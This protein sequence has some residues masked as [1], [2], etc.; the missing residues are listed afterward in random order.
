MN[1]VR[2]RCAVLLVMAAA[3]LSS[4][5]ASCAQATDDDTQPPHCTDL[6]GKITLPCP[7]A[8]Q[9]S[10]GIADVDDTAAAPA[11]PVKPQQV[12]KDA[13]AS[14]AGPPGSAPPANTKTASAEG[15]LRPTLASPPAPPTPDPRAAIGLYPKSRPDPDPE[16]PPFVVPSVAS[17]L[18]RSPELSLARNLVQDQKDIW[19]SPMRLR[20]YDVQWLAPLL[21]A[22]TVVT[23]SDTDIQR[24]LPTSPSFQKRSKQFGNYGAA[25][26]AGVTGAAWMWGRVTHNDRLRETGILSGEAALDSLA[27]VYAI[28]NVTNRDRPY[29]GNGHGSFF[30]KGNS[31]PSEHAAAAWSMAAVFAHQYPGPLTTLLAYGGAAAISAARVTGQQHFASDALVGSALGYFVGRHVYNSHHQ[32][33]DIARYGTFERAPRADAPRTPDNMGSAFVPL[34]SW[35]YAAFD[36]LAGL[37]YIHTAFAGLRPWTRLEC[38]RLLDEAEPVIQGSTADNNGALRLFRIL[39]AEFALDGANVA[40]G[41]NLSAELESLYTRVTGISGKPLNDSYHFGQT[42]INDYGRP[43]QQ[44]F[45]MVSGFTARGEAGPL[46]FYVRGEHQHAPA[47]PTLSASVA[48]LISRVD[49]NPVQPLLPVGARNDFQLLDTYVALNIKNNQISFGRQSLWWGPGQGGAM[50]FSNNALPFYVL[51]WNHVSPAKLPGLFGFLGPMRTDFFMGKLEGHHF[52][53]SPYIS[54]Q[55]VSFKPTE[56]LEIGFSKISIFAGGGVPITW[57][58]FSKA[59]FSYDDKGGNAANAPGIDAGDRRSGFDFRYRIPGLR[60]TLIL[61]S[62]SLSDDDP[63]PLAAPRRAAINPGIYLTHIPGLPRLDFRAEAAYTDTPSQTGRGGAFI[64]YNSNFHDSHTN[65]GNIMGSWVGRDGRGIQLWSTYWIS[66]ESTIRVGYRNGRISQDFIPQG[67]NL[68]DFS[69][70]A[71]FVLPHD[72]SLTTDFK[73]ERW[74]IPALS[75]E[76]QV[77]VTTSLQLTYRPKWRIK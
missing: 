38:L 66:G 19:T 6:S 20:L 59:T 34:D 71:D 70:R 37:G 64:Y 25:A 23:L 1:G 45:N 63:S 68:N 65:N 72:L 74:N 13:T 54:G 33:E 27:L 75:A 67:G 31:F 26:F 52:P 42:I 14:V 49:A 2:S 22:G 51:R 44:G 43:Y 55:K 39:Q 53:S 18:S 58:N 60:N 47:G 7:T 10:A 24:H 48:D 77:N 5:T 8:E 17:R 15:V 12:R 4:A 50:M 32:R 40:S 9:Q 35:V 56:N 21:A 3:V 46:A 62:D 36:R 28:K 29:Q 16:A 73:Y 11:P 69:A 61:Y 41:R 76:P 30:S 57:N